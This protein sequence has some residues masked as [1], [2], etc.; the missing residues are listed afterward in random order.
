MTLKKFLFTT[1]ITISNFAKSTGINENTLNT[2]VHRKSEP[3]VSNAI[4]IINATHGS[5][6]LYDLTVKKER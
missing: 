6:T 3:T 1:K 2:Y 4:K 5:V